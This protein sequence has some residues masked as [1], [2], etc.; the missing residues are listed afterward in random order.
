MVL[1]ATWIQSPYALVH[2]EDG[3]GRLLAVE[4]WKAAHV[5][6]TWEDFSFT[7]CPEGCPWAAV[8]NA[9]SESAPMGAVRVVLVPQ[10]DNLLEKARE[11]PG[12]IKTMLANPLPDTCLLLVCR[13]TLSAA[14]GRILGSKPFSEWVQQGRA[15]KVGVLDERGAVAFLEGEAAALHLTLEPGIAQ[16]LAARM[17]GH[18][19]VLRRTLEVLDLLAD[20][21]RV[22]GDLVDKATFRLADQN[23][24]AWAQAWQKGQLGPALLALRQS[25]EDDPSGAP[26]MLLGQARREVDRVCRLLEARSAGLRR[27]EDLVQAL[28]LGPRQGFLMDSYVRVADRYG[29]EGALRLLRL[30]NETDLDLKGMALS[31]SLGPLLSLTTSLSRAW[32]P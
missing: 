28:G 1:P 13:G 15:L 2:G 30:V 14:S 3:D 7:V 17:G 12:A 26:L 31:R 23:G 8:L 25:L 21:R 29:Y 9:L 11:L 16:R 22:G 18:P 6:P 32:A 4:A 19:G 5:D 10:A 27:T 24:F 20:N